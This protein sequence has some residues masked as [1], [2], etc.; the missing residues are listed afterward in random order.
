MP[1]LTFLSAWGTVAGFWPR[2]TGKIRLTRPL[3][4]GAGIATGGVVLWGYIANRYL[5]DFM[6]LLILGGAIGLVDLWRRVAERAEKQP[7]PKASRRS[8]T[9]RRWLF[10]AVLALGIFGIL[11]NTGEALGSIVQWSTPQALQYVEVQ[12]DLSL[13]SLA[14]TVKTGSTLP[15]WA[16][17]GEIFD[18]DSCSGLYISNGTQYYTIPGQNLQHIAWIPIVEGPGQVHRIEFTLSKPLG[19]FSGNIPVYQWGQA[20]VTLEPVNHD[21]ARIVIV[22]PSPAPSWPV[23]EGPPVRFKPGKHYVLS[24]E[25]DPY[26]DSLRVRY[27][28][29]GPSALAHIAKLPLDAGVQV[30]DR[31]QAGNPPQKVVASDQ[32]GITFSE[33]AGPNQSQGFSL[34]RSLQSEK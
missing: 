13:T 31:Y 4:L 8:L 14:A 24:I 2:S 15:Y 22:N 23:A 26:L 1:L 12:K 11:A 9:P 33:L 29:P 19:D 34:C 25:T 7:A 10:G 3:I 5:A 32:P 28:M 18:V 30:V 20:V 27:I 17:L 6:P 21:E 16:P